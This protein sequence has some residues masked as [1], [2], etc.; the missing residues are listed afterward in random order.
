[1]EATLRGK[2]M[3]PTKP[4]FWLR[5]VE[6][7]GFSTVFAIIFLGMFW[8][9][10]RWVG[11][12]VVIPVRD[13]H[14]RFTSQVSDSVELQG[15]AINEVKESM[16]DVR[17]VLLDINEEQ[18]KTADGVGELTTTIQRATKVLEKFQEQ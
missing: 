2:L 13:A 16:D 14:I 8:Y 12:E 10:S 17:A 11:N 1:M 7:H 9:F 3:A 18:R 6:K 4:D 5:A 15:K